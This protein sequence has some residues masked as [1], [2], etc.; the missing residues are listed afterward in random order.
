MAVR[1]EAEQR[2]VVVIKR[3]HTRGVIADQLRECTPGYYNNEGDLSGD[4]PVIAA[5]L[6]LRHRCFH[7]RARQLARRKNV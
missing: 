7:R 1:P 6:R 3:V 4:T 2:W 5:V